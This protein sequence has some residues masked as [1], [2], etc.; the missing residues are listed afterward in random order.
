MTFDKTKLTELAE[1]NRT[2]IKAVASAHGVG[3]HLSGGTSNE[4]LAAVMFGGGTETE[5][6]TEKLSEEE[7]TMQLAEQNAED[8]ATLAELLDVPT[9]KVEAGAGKAD[10]SDPLEAFAG[11]LSGSSNEITLAA[12]SEDGDSVDKLA[13]LLD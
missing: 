9:S 1:Q 6:E 10:Q 5:A 2:N 8:I 13:T 12:D 7:Q 4:K 3:S 11:L